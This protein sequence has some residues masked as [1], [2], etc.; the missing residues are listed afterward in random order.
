LIIQMEE[1]ARKCYETSFARE[2][3]KS[4]LRCPTVST[5]W[6]PGREARVPGDK[7]LE[8]AP[9]LNRSLDYLSA[10]S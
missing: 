6:V 8:T 7:V 2:L 4:A 3:R 5:C 9:L 1:S 10:S